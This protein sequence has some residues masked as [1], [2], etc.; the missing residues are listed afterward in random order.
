[1]YYKTPKKAESFFRPVTKAKKANGGAAQ[2][3]PKA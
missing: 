2:Q 3:T 1:M